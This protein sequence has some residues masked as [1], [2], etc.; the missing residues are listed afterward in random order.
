MCL[1]GNQ[2]AQVSILNISIIPATEDIFQIFFF[3]QADKLFFFFDF[4]VISRV[5][6]I[7]WE[8]FSLEN[9]LDFGRLLIVFI[10]K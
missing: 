10:I 6:I 7:F 9:E 3:R 5:N 1:T 2:P 8:C 4:I